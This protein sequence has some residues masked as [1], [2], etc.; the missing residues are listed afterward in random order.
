MKNARARSLHLF[1]GLTI[2]ISC[3]G[4]FGLA[5]YM[6]ENRIKEIGVRKVLGASVAGI[7]AL[8]SKDFL[9]LVLVAFIVATP[10]AWWAMST[11]LKD[12]SHHVAF[13]GGFVMA[14]LLS[15]GSCI[16]HHAAGV[17]TINATKTNFRKSFES[18]ALMPAT[19]APSTFRTPISFM[20]FSAMYVRVQ[21]NRDMK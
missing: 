19:D 11:W 3:L 4:L 16:A 8:L 20:R 15:F 5:T 7:S 2:F 17:A 9:K 13:S 12:Y 14:G 1:A 6:A 18:K 21:T 10:A